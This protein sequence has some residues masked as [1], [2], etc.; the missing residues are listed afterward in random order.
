MFLVRVLGKREQ[1]D[2][3]GARMTAHYLLMDVKIR[4]KNPRGPQWAIIRRSGR[5][6]TTSSMPLVTITVIQ[7]SFTSLSKMILVLVADRRRIQHY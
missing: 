2:I 4:L 3:A 7:G 6:K 1:R 5:L